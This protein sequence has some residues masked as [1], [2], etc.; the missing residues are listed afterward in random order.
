[1]ALLGEFLFLGGMHPFAS[2]FRAHTKTK[3]TTGILNS[4]ILNTLKNPGKQHAPQ[5]P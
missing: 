3:K 4:Q 2:T 1:M 5:V